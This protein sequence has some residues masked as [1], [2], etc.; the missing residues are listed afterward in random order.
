L[1]TVH[2]VTQWGGSGGIEAY[3]SGQLASFGAFVGW[4]IWPVKIVHEMTYKVSSETLS[5]YSLTHP[6]N[7]RWRQ[8]VSAAEQTPSSSIITSFFLYA[9]V[10]RSSADSANASEVSAGL[11]IPA[12]R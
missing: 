6:G 12:A 10:L 3:V 8:L 4:V 9:V 11:H 2:I 1:P 7:N 5:L